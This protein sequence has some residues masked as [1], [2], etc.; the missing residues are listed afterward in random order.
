[1]AVESMKIKMRKTNSGFQIVT[2]QDDYFSLPNDIYDS[3]IARTIVKK[4][5]SHESY[6]GKM[7]MKN[8]N[9]KTY[10]INLLVSDLKYYLGMKDIF[11]IVNSKYVFYLIL[12]YDTL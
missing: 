5:M 11:P 9:T 6:R 10:T 8:P 2:D 3:D 12:S 4:T 7:V 1:M